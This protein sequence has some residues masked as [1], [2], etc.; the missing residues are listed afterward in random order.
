MDLHVASGAFLAGAVGRR[1]I[2]DRALDAAWEIVRGQLRLLMGKEIVPHDVTPENL[3]ALIAAD[4]AAKATLEQVGTS[5]PVMRRATVVQRALQGARILWID[6]EPDG[7]AL[8]RATLGTFGVVVRTALSGEE[9]KRVLRGERF[10]LVISDI[11]RPGE[12][13]AGIKDLPLLRLIAPDLPVIFY[14]MRME[15]RGVPAGAFG[16]TARPDELL[17]LCMD[18]LERRR[19]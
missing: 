10:D 2:E 16:I 1:R 5:A 4:A 13:L 9:A 14:I 17:H 15:P 3:R 19:S 18:A 6:D 8:E 12:S 11:S 7:N